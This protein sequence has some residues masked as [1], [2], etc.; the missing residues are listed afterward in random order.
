MTYVCQCKTIVKIEV[1]HF[2]LDV[3]SQGSYHYISNYDFKT[4]TKWF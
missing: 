3:P 2:F 4:N 1:L